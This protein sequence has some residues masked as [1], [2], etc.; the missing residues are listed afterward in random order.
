MEIWLYIFRIIFIILIYLFLYEVILV[1][2]RN[3]NFKEKALSEKYPPAKL[4]ILKGK[5]KI[6]SFSAQITLSK[7]VTLGRDPYNDIIIED[8]FISGVNTRIF[9][10]V[11]SF[12]IEDLNST[13]GTWLNQKRI[14]QIVV[15]RDSDII[16]LGEVEFKFILE[17]A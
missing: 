14:T 16:G 4:L 10:K 1:I 7:A 3:L 12:Y 6:K 15:L 17:R 5:D 9:Y 13:N 8:K 2:K 11:N